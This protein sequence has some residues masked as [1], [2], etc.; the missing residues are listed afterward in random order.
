GRWLLSGERRHAGRGPR[1]GLALRVVRHWGRRRR[2]DR[3]LPRLGLRGR[4]RFVLRRP[5]HRLGRFARVRR[6]LGRRH[7]VHAIGRWHGLAR[8][9]RTGDEEQPGE[10][11]HSDGA[12]ETDARALGTPA[13]PSHRST[14]S[15]SATRPTSFTPAARIAASTCTTAAY[16]TRP[17]ARRYTPVGRLVRTKAGNVA[18]KSAYESGA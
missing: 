17:S 14:T 5:I 1:R 3:A 9:R 13:P 6:R 18:R 12:D 8:G 15:G 7:E 16:G 11:V 4:R 10:R 2:G